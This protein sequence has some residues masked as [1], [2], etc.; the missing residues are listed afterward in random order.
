[1]NWGQN[2]ANQSIKKIMAGPYDV[3]GVLAFKDG[4]RMDHGEAMKLFGA[5]W[6]KVD[7]IFFGRAADKGNGVNRLCFLEFGK[8]Q[9]CIHVHFV[10]QSPIDPVAFSAILNVLWNT[11]NLNTAQMRENWITPIHSK[12]ATA[13]YVT[14]EIW[15]FRDDRH[16]LACDR[17]TNGLIEYGSI[18]AGAAVA[19]IAS[20]V[21]AD[22]LEDAITLVP[23]HMVLIRKRMEARA[24]ATAAKQRERD[25]R[26]A[27]VTSAFRQFIQARQS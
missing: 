1:M 19:R 5:F 9:K 26:Y 23:V 22:M 17:G 25:Q 6:H 21:D 7:R 4:Q 20:C 16:V 14:K 24:H 27:S 11:F 15:R 10:A 3:T 13:E 18:D 2:V 12:L 8:S